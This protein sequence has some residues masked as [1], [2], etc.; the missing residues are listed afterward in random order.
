[1]A[2]SLQDVLA[3]VRAQNTR[4]ESL[5]ALLGGLKDALT[6]ANSNTGTTAEMQE[7]I[8]GIFAEVEK[9]T[10]AIDMALTT[11]AAGEPAR[12]GNGA[13]AGPLPD[14][15][16]TAPSDAPAE[17][18]PPPETPPPSGEQQPAN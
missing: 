6:A 1:M 13:D 2:K 16:G 9:E 18:A 12:A 7:A 11:T 8:D 15:G 4:I 5:L 3:A 10:G 17:S 14:V